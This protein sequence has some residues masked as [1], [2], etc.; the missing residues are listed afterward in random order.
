MKCSKRIKLMVICFLEII[1][2]VNNRIF[3]FFSQTL[4]KWALV[5]WLNLEKIMIKIARLLNLFKYER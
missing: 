2:I 3:T 1:N 4:A 5:Y